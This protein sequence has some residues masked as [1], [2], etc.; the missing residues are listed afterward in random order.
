MK[1]KERGKNRG[2][3]LDPL[4]R[5]TGASLQQWLC[6]APPPGGKIGQ[7]GHRQAA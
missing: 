6:K 2:H 7:N 3:R 5:A 1:I 4:K